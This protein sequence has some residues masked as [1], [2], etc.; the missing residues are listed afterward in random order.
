MTL[1]GGAAAGLKASLAPDDAAL[2]AAARQ[3]A[4]R[5]YAPYSGFHVGA[6]VLCAS[7][8]VYTA[9]N[10]ENA[11][12][13]LGICAETNAVTRAASAGERTIVRVAVA[14]YRGDDRNAAIL[15]MPCGRCRQVINEFG[16]DAVV[17]VQDADGGVVVVTIAELLPF[18]FGP[19]A[20]G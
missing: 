19:A 9:A 15:A 12:Y 17:L 8:K 5:A 16:P 6:A 20:L 1:S 10:V 13:G 14:A 3:A 18:A 11:S 2:I 7:G 4:D